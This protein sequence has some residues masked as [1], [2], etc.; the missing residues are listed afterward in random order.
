MSW[1]SGYAQD[2]RFAP[3]PVVTSA[4]CIYLSTA[5]LFGSNGGRTKG[6]V[7]KKMREKRQSQ[8][9]QRLQRSMQRKKKR[10]CPEVEKNVN[11]QDHQDKQCREFQLLLLILRTLL[12]S[13]RPAHHWL[14]ASHR[15]WQG[16]EP[17]EQNLQ[18]VASA[19]SSLDMANNLQ[20]LGDE[21]Q[22]E[23]QSSSKAIEKLQGTMQELLKDDP[24]PG[25]GST[26]PPSNIPKPPAIPPGVD[27]MSEAYAR[28][29][30][31]QGV[32]RLGHGDPEGV[33]QH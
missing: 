31:R 18:E 5:I 23:I 1:R 4:I 6:R 26:V 3:G 28:M 30:L 20:N 16:R 14:W 17:P 15:Q 32:P 9:G 33:H 11:V 25:P 27:T 22:G 21:I 19:I 8:G 10:N 13:C 2:L 24:A 7:V 12:I 29:L